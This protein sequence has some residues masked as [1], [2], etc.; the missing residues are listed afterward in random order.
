MV[1]FTERVSATRSLHRTKTKTY[2]HQPRRLQDVLC[3]RVTLPA[4]GARF[5]PVSAL[6]LRRVGTHVTHASD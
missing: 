2:T 1:A 3:G 6:I 5:A 4:M